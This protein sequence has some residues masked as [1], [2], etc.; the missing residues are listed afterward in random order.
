VAQNVNTGGGAAAYTNATTD[1]SGTWTA[2]TTQMTSPSTSYDVRHVIYAGGKF[3]A[4]G[5]L[6][7]AGAYS[8]TSTNGTSWTSN[9]VSGSVT[10]NWFQSVAYDGVSRYVAVGDAASPSPI[11]YSSDGNTWTA[12]TVPTAWV[13][14]AV[15]FSNVVYANGFFIAVSSNTNT[16]GYS[17]NGTSWSTSTSPFA[18]T[19]IFTGVLPS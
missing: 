6:S 17:T 15:G 7:G 11:C 8:H 18:S 9:A 3:V 19:N 13:T 1:G 14:N 2:A 12:A 10:N 16:I 5:G 4:V